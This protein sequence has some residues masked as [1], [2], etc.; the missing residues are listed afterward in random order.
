MSE[1]YNRIED[2]CQESGVTVTAM[3]KESGVTRASLTDLK[4]G[5]KK[6]INAQTAQKIAAYLGVSVSYL[7]GQGIIMNIYYYKVTGLDIPRF[8]G[9]ILRMAVVPGLMLVVGLFALEHIALDGWMPF[10]MGV[11][12]Y[13]AIYCLLMYV[14]AMNDY[15]KDIIR[16]PLQK[17]LRIVKRK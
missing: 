5:R 4:M 9:N 2:L 11:A 16:K 1:L 17:I 8:W 7:L 3:C 10:L 15:E 12:V 13:T 6:G 14:F